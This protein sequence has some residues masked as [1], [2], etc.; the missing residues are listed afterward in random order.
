[1]TTL[2]IGCNGSIG[3]RHCA[4]LKHIGVD[5]EGYD[6]NDKIPDFDKFDNFII[7]TPTNTHFRFIYELGQYRKPILCEKP[8]SIEREDFL[9]ILNTDIKLS[10]M[11]QYR[12]FDRDFDKGDSRY[13]FY[14]HG[15]DGLVWDCFQ[16]IALARGKVTIGEDSPIWDCVLN[17]RELDLR[18]MDHAY[19]WAIKEFLDGKYISKDKL[20][21]YHNKV[22]NY[23]SLQNGVYS[24][25]GKK[26]ID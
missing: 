8:L 5:F 9:K 15:K 14:N 12:Y 3:K 10:M 2:V 7:A 20:L 1:M 6:I 17:G 11:M 23:E 4:V 25:P 26:Y 19:I 16:V 24:H 18:K 22:R 21:E 13:N